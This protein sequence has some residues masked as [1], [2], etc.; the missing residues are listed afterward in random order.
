MY[1]HTHTHTHT[2]TPTHTHIQSYTIIVCFKCNTHNMRVMYRK[3][4]SYN[5]FL[6]NTASATCLFSA[7]TS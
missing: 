4:H 3:L 7:A 1:T 6:P 2:H 5:I